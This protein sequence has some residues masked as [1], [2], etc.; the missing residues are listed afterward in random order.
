VKKTVDFRGRQQT[1]LH[2]HHRRRGVEILMRHNPGRPDHLGA[3]GFGLPTERVSA[4]LA[5]YSCALGDCPTAA[6]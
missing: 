2:A 5:R 4:M 6:G 1:Y 3:Y